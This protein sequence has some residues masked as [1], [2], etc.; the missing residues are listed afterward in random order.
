MHMAAAFWIPS[1]SRRHFEQRCAVVQWA[2]GETLV[3]GVPDYCDGEGCM[4]DFQSGREFC[5]SG[6]HCQVLTSRQWHVDFFRDGGPEYTLVDTFRSSFGREFDS[7]G[8]EEPDVPPGEAALYMIDKPHTSGKSGDILEVYVEF[9]T[10]VYNRSDLE[11]LP[12]GGGDTGNPYAAQPCGEVKWR[13]D[14]EPWVVP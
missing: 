3:N 8:Y 2:K 12:K 5:P 6:G 13:F 7:L 1:A 4:T 9:I 10:A 11:L 14:L